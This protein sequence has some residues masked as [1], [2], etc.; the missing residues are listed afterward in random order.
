MSERPKGESFG[1]LEIEQAFSVVEKKPE[2]KKN[3]K[4]GKL[5]NIR[6]SEKYL[7]GYDVVD[8]E[9][10]LVEDPDLE[11]LGAF[12]DESIIESRER[13][14][15]GERFNKI[16]DQIHF[17]AKVQGQFTESDTLKNNLERISRIR[18]D[19]ENLPEAHEVL[20]KDF[21][22]FPKE[23][24]VLSD[25]PEEEIAIPLIPVITPRQ[26]QEGVRYKNIEG[27][28]PK[29]FKLEKERA[30]KGKT[31][32]EAKYEITPSNEAVI[33]ETKKPRKP[34]IKIIDAEIT[35]EPAKF[36]TQLL[37]GS[38]GKE[39][40]KTEKEIKSAIEIAMEKTQGVADEYNENKLKS[41]DIKNARNL[42]ELFS[43]IEKSEGI[44]GSQEYFD[45][46]KLKMIIE[47]VHDGE[48]GYEYITRSGGLRQKVYDLLNKSKEPKKIK[49][50]SKPKNPNP[51]ITKDNS[52]VIERESVSD[53]ERDDNLYIPEDEEQITE[54]P[55]DKIS[56]TV[57]NF[58]DKKKRVGITKDG[59][60]EVL[61]ERDVTQS[62]PENNQV[63]DLERSVERARRNY[64]NNVK[65]FNKIGEELANQT[66]VKSIFK[67][68]LAKIR[69]EP[70]EIDIAREQMMVS[71]RVYHKSLD[72]IRDFLVEQKYNEVVSMRANNS[73]RKKYEKVY[74]S[75]IFKFMQIFIN[76]PVTK[77]F[78]D[79][80][81]S[82]DDKEIDWKELESTGVLSRKEID[83]LKK[84][85]I[86]AEIK[87]EIFED[88][89]KKED[90]LLNRSL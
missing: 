87:K 42:D 17:E 9:D 15:E 66:S 46:D 79:F 41:E 55:E 22:D 25:F 86:F 71:E 74:A 51:E 57:L 12:V 68:F 73:E 34:P 81:D 75:D 83:Q 2:K 62:H 31:K 24:I 88:L 47:M 50:E 21:P 8:L 67:K 52:E 18:K 26:F 59:K 32:K 35:E 65:K 63:T 10:H 28:D 23:K 56:G 33:V 38:G 70:S 36:E 6:K 20:G 89:K 45:K 90:E 85:V 40:Q 54:L 61:I 7:R 53:Q 16:N 48:L 5:K 69:S 84:E 1:N 82:K 39:Q 76:K 60:Q 14:E 72:D 37:E 29:K 49:K 13:G 78:R 44:Q 77:E 19:I 58:N 4:E 11:K 64:I 3:K 80:L 30:E 27:Y 43:L